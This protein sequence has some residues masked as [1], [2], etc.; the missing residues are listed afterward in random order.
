[1]NG[2][3]TTGRRAGYCRPE[4]QV[5]TS[6]ESPDL[7]EWD[8]LLRWDDVITEYLFLETAIDGIIVNPPIATDTRI[9]CRCVPITKANGTTEDLC[10]KSGIVGTLT[11]EQ[12]RELCLTREPLRH[13]EGF[14]RHIETF[15]RASE[16]CVAEGANTLE[17]RI[18]CM[19]RKLR[20]AAAQG[21]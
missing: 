17:S 7:G 14:R 10:F 8:E 11:Q 2:C 15:Q 3:I 13:P 16:E 12:A 1:M 18:S 6:R 19:G 9:S 20:E 5:E 21:T 4:R